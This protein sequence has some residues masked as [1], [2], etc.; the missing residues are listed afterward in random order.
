[1]A[2]DRDLA[3]L[4]IIMN[5]LKRSVNPIP[6][7]KIH[8]DMVWIGNFAIKPIESKQ[9]YEILWKDEEL[10]SMGIVEAG[11]VTVSLLTLSYHVSA[12]EFDD[13]NN[14]LDGTELEDYKE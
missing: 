1:M 11:V 9:K 13:L 6:I 8:D 12:Q 10:T 7:V 3:A 4:F 14:L 2:M 5:N